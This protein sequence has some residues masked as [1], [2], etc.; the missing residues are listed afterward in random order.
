MTKNKWELWKEKN[1]GDSVRPWDMINPKIE[2]IS[3]EEAKKRLDICF[4]CDRLIKLTTQCKECGC[5]MNLKTKLPHASC[6]I[7][8]W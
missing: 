8:K 3:E 6:P 1:P 5:F 4:S 7:G 2:K